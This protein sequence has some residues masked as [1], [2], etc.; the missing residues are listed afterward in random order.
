VLPEVSPEVALLAYRL[1]YIGLIV[2]A[3]LVFGS[4]L[5]NFWS[6]SELK[7]H[8][9]LRLSANER[10]T[11]QSRSDLATSN[12]RIAELSTQADELRRDTAEANARAL[13]AQLALTREIE[14]NTTRGVSMQQYEA[15]QSLKGKVAEISLIWAPASET[16]WFAKNVEMAFRQAD[17][18]VATPPTPPNFWNVG[19]SIF[20]PGSPVGEGPITKS[21]TQNF[22]WRT[23]ALAR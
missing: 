1:A 6:D 15:I 11:A 22:T 21:L 19:N 13:E 9:D 2:G 5:V 23:W 18:S 10:E 14:Q 8:D 7:R 12:E 20:E 4:T 3:A 17:I 16:F